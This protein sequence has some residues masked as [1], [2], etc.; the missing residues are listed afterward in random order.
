MASGQTENYGLNQWAAEDAV[1]REEFNRDNAKLDVEMESMADNVKFI[2]LTE[3]I[4]PADTKQFAVT[5]PD[6]DLSSFSQLRLVIYAQTNGYSIYL[7]LNGQQENVYQTL[8]T[9]NN[10]SIMSNHLVKMPA[11]SYISAE[12]FLA[13]FAEDR[14]T[15][16]MLH[17][18][19]QAAADFGHWPTAGRGPIPFNSM[20]TLDFYSDGIIKAESRFS[21]YGVLL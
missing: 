18:L 20:R 1:L 16:C 8:S 2:K 9:N 6:T 11:G 13:P 19:C 14:D 4:V 15:C 12:G 17:G 10:I 5:I 21:L 3:R 7:R